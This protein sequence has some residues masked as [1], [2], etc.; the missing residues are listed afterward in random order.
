MK[1]PESLAQ[2]MF[3]LALDPEKGKLH[4]STYLRPLLRSAALTELYLSG[5]LRDEKGKPAIEVAGPCTD[6]VLADL[7]EEIGSGRPR[8][9]AHWVNKNARRT[10]DAVRDQL[11]DG[12]LVRAEPYRVL[13]LFPSTRYTLRDPR[14]RTRLLSTVSAVLR[15]PV[16]RVDPAEAALVSLSVLGRLN[17]VVTRAKRKEHKAKIKTLTEITGPAAP[18][19]KSTLES[20]DAAAAG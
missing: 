6:P 12:G 4:T 5:H 2:R 8:K 20:Y 11:V 18:A 10:A 15:D 17:K 1:Q 3:V 16:G 9:W 7:L 19:L 14:V 13:G